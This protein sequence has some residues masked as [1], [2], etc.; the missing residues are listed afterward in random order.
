MTSMTGYAIARPYRLNLDSYALL[1]GV[2]PELIRRL[3]AL[4]L[5]DISRDSQGGLWFEPSQVRAMARIQRLHMGLNL[6]YASL[7]LIVDLLDRISQLERSQRRPL[8]EGE[9]RGP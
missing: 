9:F 6:S 3:V 5:L 4:G 1:T 8:S 2:H 7:G